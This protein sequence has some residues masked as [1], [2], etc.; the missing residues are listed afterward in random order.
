MNT[1]I[2]ATAEPDVKSLEWRVAGVSVAG[3]SHARS[4]LVCQDNR[5]WFAAGDIVGMAVADGAGSRP[6]SQHGSAV[7][8][9]AAIIHLV[10][11]YDMGTLKNGDGHAESWFSRWQFFKPKRQNDDDRLR[12]PLKQSFAAAAKAVEAEAAELGT[13]PQEL[14]T[15]L[16]VALA[17]PGFVAAAQ[18]GDGAVVVEDADSNLFALTTP[19]SGEFVNESG[20]LP[21]VA[22][23]QALRSGYDSPS[24]H[25]RP[26]LHFSC[27]PTAD[28]SLNPNQL[29]IEVQIDLPLSQKL[30]SFCDS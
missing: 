19:A 8:V 10:E 1:L 5:A 3:T 23:R 4:G 7:A 9:R 20:R 24:A 6:L 18:V 15:T 21:S 30:G 12:V 22:R 14:A 26:P 13:T 29:R 27:S 25:L 11:Q 2:T 28:R 16:I 17:G